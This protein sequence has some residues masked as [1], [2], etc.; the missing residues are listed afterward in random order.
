MILVF[1]GS[2]ITAL[3][4]WAWY[5]KVQVFQD[6][7]LENQLQTSIIELEKSNKKLG[8]KHFEPQMLPR[9]QVRNRV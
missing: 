9:P 5:Y 3:S 7:I 2:I 4:G 6:R 8:R 1:V